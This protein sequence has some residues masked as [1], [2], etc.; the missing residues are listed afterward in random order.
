MKGQPNKHGLAKLGGEELPTKKPDLDNVLKAVL[1]GLNGIAFVDDSQ[2]VAI[3][4][5]KKY[6]L[7]PSV[8]VAI[9]RWPLPLELAVSGCR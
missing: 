8:A 6:T 3:T 4:V 7:T 2:V 9:Y 1:D 5:R